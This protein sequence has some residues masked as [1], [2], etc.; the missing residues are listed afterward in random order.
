MSKRRS[1][2]Y[3]ARQLQAIKLKLLQ[4]GIHPSQVNLV[5]AQA[6]AWGHAT[7]TGMNSTTTSTT[8]S[9]PWYTGSS[10]PSGIKRKRGA[11][12]VDGRRHIRCGNCDKYGHNSRTCG[13]PQPSGGLLPCRKCGRIRPKRFFPSG[14]HHYRGGKFVW[15]KDCAK[16]YAASRRA[17]KKALKCATAP[18]TG[19]R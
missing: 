12:R 15:C 8:N 6:T 9:A 17:L 10:L 3:S 16:A 19:M 13:K 4:H 2:A 14:N 7:V 5:S 1:T 18:A 11:V